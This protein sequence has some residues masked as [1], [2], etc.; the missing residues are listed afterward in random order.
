MPWEEM[1]V[2]RPG[3]VEVWELTTVRGLCNAIRIQNNKIYALWVGLDTWS[4]TTTMQALHLQLSAN[5][6]NSCTPFSEDMEN[7]LHISMFPINFHG[8]PL[9]VAPAE[10]WPV[11]MI[12]RQLAIFDDLIASRMAVPLQIQHIAQLAYTMTYRNVQPYRRSLLLLAAEEVEALANSVRKLSAWKP[13]DM[14]ASP[15]FDLTCQIGPDSKFSLRNV[16]ASNGRYTLTIES[17]KLPDN[18]DDL[19]ARIWMSKRPSRKQQQ[20]LLITCIARIG[21]C[22]CVSTCVS[23]DLCCVL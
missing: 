11:G 19:Q 22:V 6:Y 3:G 20:Q 21:V 17:H 2:Y 23:V 15:P 4:H 10:V 1:L 8:A 18:H 7:T 9:V 16:A 13:G 5:D 14:S 12:Y